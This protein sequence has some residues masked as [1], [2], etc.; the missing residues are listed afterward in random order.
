[1]RMRSHALAL[2]LTVLLLGSRSL[3][4]TPGFWEAATQADFLRG[5]VEHLSI[6]EHGRLMLG[7]ALR[8]VHD[9][10]VPFVWTMI[11]G[12]DESWFLGTGNDG[13]VI[14]VDRS[15][16]GSV[17]YD[18]AEMEVH[19]LASAPNG[20]LYVATSPDGRIYQVDARGQATPFFDPD[21]KYIWALAVDG[22]GAVYAATG[23]K[24]VVYRI[25]ADGKGTPFFSTKAAHAVSLGFDQGGRLLVGTG[26]PGRVFRVDAEGKG[27][28]LLDTAYQEIKALRVDGKG[29]VYVAAQSGRPA[30]GGDS[31]GFMGAPSD[32]TP[33]VPQPTV[34][35]EITSIAIIDAPVSAQPSPSTSPSDRR[36]PTGAVYR[37]QVDGLWDQ[38]WESREDAPYDL[39]VNAD[40]SLVVATGARGKI[41]RLAGDPMRATLLTRVTAQQA[42]LIQRTATRTLIAT[43]NPGQ[44]LSMSNERAATGSYESDVK[45]ARLV[46]SWGSISWRA[47]T[48]SGTRLEI[49]TRSGNTRTPDDAWSAWSDP[50]ASSTGSPI[51][52]P[53]ARYLQWRAVLSGKNDSP[54]LTSVSAAYLQRNVRPDVAS[55]TVHPPGIV[56]QKPFS[57]DADIAGFAEE[58]AERKLAG[59]SSGLGPGAPSLGRRTYQK[60]LRTFVW[61]AE[62]ANEDELTYDIMYRREGETTWKLL[63]GGLTETIHVWDTSSAPNGAYVMKVVAWDAR[64]NPADTALRGERESDSFDIDNGPPVVT[65]SPLQKDGGQIVVPF[66]VRDTDSPVTRVEYSLDAQSWQGA[67]PADGILDGRQERFSVR[68][69]PA[70]SGRMLVVRATDAMNNVGTAEVLVR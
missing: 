33:P 35:A 8:T 67:F 28:L 62:D 58:P 2:G 4:A 49:R 65:M 61:K 23:D 7:P 31:V 34:S 38:L 36:G 10:G 32:P 45:D 15:G 6:D 53:K 3:V 37:I 59:G 1:M 39:A 47:T 41:F 44:L 9:A 63:K 19:A 16:N 25:T 42:T 14:R 26:S 22:N 55:L 12:P 20:G 11:P 40:G 52:S 54:V 17:F 13:R 50:Y 24:G 70:M 56:F 57:P 30:Q 51:V 66:E 46:S 64:S 27:F 60:G 21:D 18:S 48:P 29:A 5:D 68:L 43:A 69:D